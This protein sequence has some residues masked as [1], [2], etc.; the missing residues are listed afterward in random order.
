M[1]EMLRLANSGVSYRY[2]E[3]PVHQAVLLLV[4]GLGAHTERWD[5]L[6]D[7]FNRNG[8][9]CFGLELRGFGTT[10]DVRGH[11][12][13]FNIYHDDLKKLT[14]F[15]RKYH[16]GKPVFLLGESLGSLISFRTVA[17]SPDLFDG[18]ICIS[19]AFLSALKFGIRD[20]LALLPALLF[21]RKKQLQ[22]PFTA[23]MCTSDGSYQKV[24]ENN[25]LET[26]LASAALLWGSLMAQLAAPA[27]AGKIK[28]PVLF[29]L[30]G[31]DYLVVPSASRKIFKKL[32]AADKTLLEYPKML[33]ALSIEKDRDKVFE[34]I[35]EWTS[36]RIQPVKSV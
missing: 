30:S 19:P 7:F 4:H 11:V 1:A 25:P 24:M 32:A 3:K 21:N 29:L 34:D 31:C 33:H 9:E 13:S 17:R 12:D 18:L 36:K 27:D 16:P 8:F 28:M 22:V 2:W 5:F 20:Y 10:P 6:A 15:I 14:E 26:R 23:Q 35:L